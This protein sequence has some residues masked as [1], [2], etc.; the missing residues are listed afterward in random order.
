MQSNG[1]VFASQYFALFNEDGGDSSGFGLDCRA[2]GQ[3]AEIGI[4]KIR[5]VEDEFDNYMWVIRS[6][7]AVQV[8]SVIEVGTGM[9]LVYEVCG[10]VSVSS[11]YG[12]VLKRSNLWWLRS[13][14]IGLAQL[15]G[16]GGYRRC[17]HGG[18]AFWTW[19]S[20][21]IWWW[22]NNS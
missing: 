4:A 20:C 14:F 6:A 17:S 22:N 9:V 2:E 8:T 12:L 13:G 10:V 18:V 1:D 16:N 11:D 19:R 5:I 21:W 7:L 15:A 3:R